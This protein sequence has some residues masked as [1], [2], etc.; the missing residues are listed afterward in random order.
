MTHPAHDGPCEGP[1]MM[2]K[3]VWD[4]KPDDGGRPKSFLMF[5]TDAATAVV[6]DPARWSYKKPVNARLL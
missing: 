4:L 5:A 1:N 6:N 3:T 2:H